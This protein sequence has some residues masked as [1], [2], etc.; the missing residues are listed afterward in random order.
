MRTLTLRSPI[1]FDHIVDEENFIDAYRKTQKGQHYHSSGARAFRVHEATNIESLRRSL[2]EETY[3]PKEY[4]NFYVYEPKKRCIYAPQYGDKIVQHAVNNILRDVY[5]PTFI[6]DSYACIRNKG[7]QAA[8]KRLHYFVRSAHNVYGHNAYVVRID[9]RKFFYSI[10]RGVLKR[11]IDRDITCEGTKN[12]L[13][14]II[15][16]SPGDKGHPLGNLTSQLFANILLNELDQYAKHR[17]KF[18]YYL[19][20]ADD[21]FIIVRNVDDAREALGDITKFLQNVL[22]LETH[23]KKSIIFPLRHGFT[24]LGFRIHLNQVAFGQRH[25]T[26]LKNIRKNHNGSEL[27]H[28]RSHSWMAHVSPCTENFLKPYIIEFKFVNKC[29]K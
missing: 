4:H 24:G 1:L 2:I 10:D 28:Q 6:F 18:R 20:Y 19:R 21:V 26:L 23:K 13:S 9:I 12:L 5:E 3:A 29:I 25:Y 11:I 7:N 17:L 14:V 16:S 8:V 22:L 15:D 27:Y